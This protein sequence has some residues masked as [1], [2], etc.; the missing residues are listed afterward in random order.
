M[1]RGNVSRFVISK[2]G[3][4]V[5]YQADQD[6][7]DMFELYSVPITGGTAVRLNEA[8]VG[9]GDVIES[10]RITPNS[11]GV[12]YVADQ[13]TDGVNEIY[14]VPI[15]GGTVNKLNLTLVSGGSVGGFF[16]VAPNDLG[17][18]YTADQE[19][20]GVTELYAASIFGGAVQKL[21]ATL[22]AGGSVYYAS[23][24]IAPD[25]RAVIYRADQEVDEQFELFVTLQG[26]DMYLPLVV[27]D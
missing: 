4:Q 25:S 18:V 14:S 8:M 1:L 2:D 10:Y 16:L 20:D 27:N 19:V 3:Q 9:G 21:D 15:S 12:V 24:K 11:L 17:V 26:K 6:A 22:T 5:V 23:I 7:D 13:E